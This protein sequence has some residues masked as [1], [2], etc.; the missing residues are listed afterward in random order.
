M[1]GDGNSKAVRIK[2]VELH[3]LPVKART[4]YKFGQY[5]LESVTCARV[6]V[7]VERNDGQTA[8]GWGETPLSVG[9]AWPGGDAMERLQAM[10]ILCRNFARELPAFAE[11]G[12][13]MEIS[14]AFQE[15]NQFDLGEAGIGMPYLPALVCF[16]AFDLALYD[17]FGRVHGVPVFEALGRDWM[18]RDLSHYLEA[19]PDAETDF[20]NTFPDT[21]LQHPPAQRLPAWHSVGAGDC[22]Q[23]EDLTGSE[24]DDGYPNTLV[25]WIRRDG[26]RCL[27]IKLTGKEY[28]WDLQRIIDIGKIAQVENCDWLCA[29][30]NSTVAEVDYVVDMLGVLKAD[31]PETYARLLYVEQPF[32]YEMEDSP[33]DVHPVSSLKPLYMDES[34]HD[35][36]LVREGRRRGWNGVALKTCKTLSSALLMLAWSRA[37]GLPLMVQD[38]TNPRLAQVTHALLAAHAGTVMGLETNSMQFYPEAS[39]EEAKVHPGL[40][41]R[42]DG[43]LDLSTL[44]GPGFGYGPITR[45]HLLDAQE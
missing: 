12:H 1:A 42:V 38:L 19:D 27:K 3:F 32:H 41:N 18:S 20:K 24:P 13:P 4:P 11:Q 17:A 7:T 30:Y 23:P 26:I 43:H 22:L 36:R 44:Q 16:S 35:W 10:E 9:W 25:D 34:A 39:S 28:A 21:F 37:H 29:D 5:S 33:A 40:F 6:A 45:L 14:M 15:A 8:T 31:H 2:D